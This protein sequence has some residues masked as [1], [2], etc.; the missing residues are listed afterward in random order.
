MK[1]KFYSDRGARCYSCSGTVHEYQTDDT[2]LLVSVR[3]LT[4][5]APDCFH[6]VRLPQ[7][8]AQCSAAH[9]WQ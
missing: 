1:N 8:A 6:T 3:C 7:T 4:C 2:V 5:Y 9:R